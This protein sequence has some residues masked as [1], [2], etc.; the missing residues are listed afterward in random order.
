MNDYDVVRLTESRFSKHTRQTTEQWVRNVEADNNSLVWAIKI[1]S[2]HIGNIKLGPVD[3]QHSFAYIGLI[4]GLKT[5]WGNGY[6]TKAIKLVVD[7]AFNVAQIHKLSATFYDENGA[8][9]RAFEK[10]GFQV[11][12]CESSHYYLEGKFRDRLTMANIN[13]LDESIL[14]QP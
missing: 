12:A 7:W 5:S 1:G 9:V 4:I 8:S 2:E 14:T 6:A 3:R 13:P 10:A 11:E